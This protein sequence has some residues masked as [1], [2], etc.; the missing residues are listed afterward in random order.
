MLVVKDLPRG[1]SYVFRV[2]FVTRQE[3]GSFSDPS[4]PVVMAT[5]PEGKG[6]G[7]VALTIDASTRLL[8]TATT[9]IIIIIYFCIIFVFKLNLMKYR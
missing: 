4:H 6:N 8:W 5:H 7:P 3:A 1:A 9:D 2:G